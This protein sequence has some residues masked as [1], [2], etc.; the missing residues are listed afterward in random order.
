MQKIKIKLKLLSDMYSHGD[1]MEKAEFRITELKALMRNTFREIYSFKN[2]KDMIE[3]E[4]ALFGN[5]KHK[6]PVSF[7]LKSIVPKEKQDSSYLRTNT[8]VTLYMMIDDFNS[9]SYEFYLY[10][11]IQSSILGGLGK[12]CKKGKGRFK[13]EKVE[14]EG[15][16]KY[17]NLLNM[18]HI[19][20]LKNYNDLQYNIKSE[21][22]R[23]R[24]IKKSTDTI[25]T[26]EPL[27]EDLKFPY[28]KE[29]SF[30]KDFPKKIYNNDF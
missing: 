5:T 10:L 3:K 13:I 4:G 17:E 23:L 16:S 24:K 21:T 14:I 11:L 12:D 29:I 26:Y 2:L 15:K 8:E 19:D 27:V 20:F 1:N 30:A 9:D 28:L 22:I 25:V 18:E 7:R 6:S